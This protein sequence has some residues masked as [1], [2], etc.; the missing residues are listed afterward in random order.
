VL[1][2]IDFPIVDL[3]DPTRLAFEWGWL[4][5]TLANFVVY[6]G[7]VLVFVLGATVRLPGARK[8]LAAAERRN[9]EASA[10]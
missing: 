10:R 4:L 3:A 6:A 1:L 9:G 2:G 5:M 8:D 7:I